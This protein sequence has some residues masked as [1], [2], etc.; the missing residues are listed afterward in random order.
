MI[1]FWISAVLCVAV[2]SLPVAN[3]TAGSASSVA[4]CLLQQSILQERGDSDCEAESRALL[5]LHQLVISSTKFIPD[6]GRVQWSMKSLLRSGGTHGWKAQD[7]ARK[8][9]EHMRWSMAME[10]RNRSAMRT[11]L[12][13]WDWLSLVVQTKFPVFLAVVAASK[14]CASDACRRAVRDASQWEGKIRTLHNT[15]EY[16]SLKLAAVGTLSTHDSSLRQPHARQII[17]QLNAFQL[18][19]KFLVSEIQGWAKAEPHWLNAGEE[20]GLWRI[21]HVVQVEL[22]YS[23]PCVG[24][25]VETNH[26]AS[27]AHTLCFADVGAIQ[28]AVMGRGYWAEADIVAHIFLFAAIQL[29]LAPKHSC[30]IDVG[31]NVGSVALLL[32]KLGFVVDA[33][34]ADSVNVQGLRHSIWRTRLEAAG[35]PSGVKWHGL[36]GC[37]V[38]S[39]RLEAHHMAASDSQGTLMIGPLTNQDTASSAIR[40]SDS[41]GDNGDENLRPVGA[42]TLDS[43]FCKRGAPCYSGRRPP[44]RMLK[45]DIEGSEWRALLGAQQTLA[46]VQVIALE[47]Y[48]ALLQ[49][50]GC[51]SP[52]LLAAAL[53]GFDRHYLIRH[54]FGKGERCRI[55]LYPLKRCL[56][57]S[58][59]EGW[60]LCATRRLAENLVVTRKPLYGISVQ[61]LR[62]GE[63]VAVEVMT[64]HWTPSLDVVQVGGGRGHGLYNSL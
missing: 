27:L 2:G 64:Q 49:K 21:L 57:L 52:V 44:V 29:D 18:M 56:S 6:I 10:A 28:S 54:S 14:A 7:W 48:P 13:D 45:L 12:W 30:I 25:P 3:T 37:T 60:H 4:Y 36:R 16:W 63:S 59:W 58:S 33:V 62:A 46:N 32:A 38:E 24:I 55:L 17:G 23:P 8:G 40:W 53:P 1:V 41:N 22:Q 42:F 50:S 15:I 34:E 39:G 19:I 51:S 43:V 61:A 31:A 11:F 20:A 9:C 47:V 35:F 26:I 5:K